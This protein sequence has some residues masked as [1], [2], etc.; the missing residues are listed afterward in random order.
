ME[1]QRVVTGQVDAVKV[2]SLGQAVKAVNSAW[3]TA[4]T[5]YFMAEWVNEDRKKG[6][7]AGWCI[8]RLLDFL[9][10]SLAKGPVS[11]YQASTRE[12]AWA[13]MTRL[14][15]LYEETVKREHENNATP[16][17]EC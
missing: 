14:D 11:L 17:K 7:D 5:K 3:P 12:D 10:S 6:I 15:A 4:I 16:D 13:I 9:D 8:Y 1:H 2:T